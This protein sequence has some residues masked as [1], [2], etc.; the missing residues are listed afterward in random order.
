[1]SKFAVK[2]RFFL[3]S[4][5]FDQSDNNLQAK[6]EDNKPLHAFPIILSGIRDMNQ[7]CTL[8]EIKIKNNHHVFSLIRGNVTKITT[9]DLETYRSLIKLLKQNNF[10]GYTFAPHSSIA[11][12]IVFKGIHS[13][14]PKEDYNR[15]AL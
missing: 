3:F 13:S 12:R 9:V 14:I 2:N 11:Y 1:M 4:T 6:R 8:I 15:S 10:I 7:L 5:C